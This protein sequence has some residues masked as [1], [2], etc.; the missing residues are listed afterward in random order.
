MSLSFHTYCVR[1]GLLM[2]DVALCMKS[3]SGAMNACITC[4]LRVERLQ[5]PSSLYVAIYGFILCMYAC[6]HSCYC[7]YVCMYVCRETV[8]A[9]A[10]SA[11]AATATTFCSANTYAEHPEGVPR[12][13]S[14]LCERIQVQHEN[15]D[16]CRSN[17]KRRWER[18]DA[19]RRRS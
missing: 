16:H 3:A 14:S 8:G 11:P 7:M 6:M 5:V 13:V 19:R 17:G 2:D 1:S 18:W 12:G 9:V 15:K 4:C 10:A